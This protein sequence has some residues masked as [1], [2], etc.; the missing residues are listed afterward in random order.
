MSSEV[1]IEQATRPKFS[2]L[3]IIRV[4]FYITCFGVFFLVKFD[5]AYSRAICG[6]D[7]S[8]VRSSIYTFILILCIQSE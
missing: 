3:G 4:L 5:L 6:F 1:S 2:A 8:A 7:Q